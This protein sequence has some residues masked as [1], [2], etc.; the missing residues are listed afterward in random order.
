VAMFDAAVGGAGQSSSLSRLRSALVALKMDPANGL[1][2]AEGA[3]AYVLSVRMPPSDDERTSIDADREE[4]S[5]ERPAK[6]VICHATPV[7]SS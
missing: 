1:P 7:G 4:V 5:F 3:K 2:A 6:G